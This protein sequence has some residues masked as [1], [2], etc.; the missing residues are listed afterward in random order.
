MRRPQVQYQPQTVPSTVTQPPNHTHESPDIRGKEIW[1]PGVTNLSP[2][3][4]PYHQSSYPGVQSNQGI[5]SPRPPPINSVSS[6]Q[7]PHNFLAGKPRISPN[8][9][10]RHMH[11]GQ[12]SN[13]PMDLSQHPR[14]PYTNK[15]NYRPPI[16]STVPAPVQQF[17][18]TLPNNYLQNHSI[19]SAP[20]AAPDTNSALYSKEKYL[21]HDRVALLTRPGK[22]ASLSMPPGK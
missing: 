12:S 1:R 6:P 8:S 7:Y 2:A 21:Q 14:H 20:L 22:S 5:P 4:Q 16:H 13:K 19:G 9:I 17:N 18:H 15:I 3:A 10:G 11:D